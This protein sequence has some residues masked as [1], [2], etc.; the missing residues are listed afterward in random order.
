METFTVESANNYTD[1]TSHFVVRLP[2]SDG[3]IDMLYLSRVE[4]PHT[5]YDVPNSYFLF[6]EGGEYSQILVPEDNYTPETLAEGL[7]YLFNRA[8][9]HRANYEVSFNPTTRRFTIESSEPFHLFHPAKHL[10]SIYPRIGLDK[11][12]LTSEREKPRRKYVGEPIE[13]LKERKLRVKVSGVARD[14]SQPN[15]FEV[16]ILSEYGDKNINDTLLSTTSPGLRYLT[17]V[18]G[19][20][21]LMVVDVLRED[22]SYLELHDGPVKITFSCTFHNASYCSLL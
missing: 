20:P 6:R 13:D 22:G 2:Y 16:P 5:F 3:E 18:E 9:P 15:W 14:P 19:V 1:K 12:A 10:T 21:R 17:W 4:I 11:I 8:S 7:E